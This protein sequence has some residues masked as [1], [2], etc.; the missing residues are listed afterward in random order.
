[1]PEDKNS[2]VEDFLSG[3]GKAKEDPFKSTDPFAT[4]GEEPTTEEETNEV[5]EEKALPFHKDPKLQKFIEKEVSRRIADIT[6]ATPVQLTSK[7][8]GDDITDVLTRIIG[9]DTPEKQAAVKDFHK[10]L[11]GLEEKGAQKALAQLEQQAQQERDKDTQAQ[12]ELE[13]SFTDIEDSYGVDLSSNT[14]TARK[15]RSDF[16]EFV[17]QVAPKNSEGE[18]IGYPD[19]NAAFEV[20]QERNKRNPVRAK[21]LASNGMTRSSD[22]SAAPVVADKSWKGVEKL[23]S[24]LSN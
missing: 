9:N 24:K 22:A 11:S 14:A 6:P 19:M 20:F 15:T 1:M 12:Q 5:E 13:D 23:F 4:L 17:R 16:V 7:E 21:Q 3:L 10:V 18:V 2:A 8:T